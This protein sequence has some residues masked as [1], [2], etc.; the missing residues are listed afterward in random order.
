MQTPYGI[1]LF[2]F[3]PR[4]RRE[5]NDSWLIPE[6]VAKVGTVD[7]DFAVGLVAGCWLLVPR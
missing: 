5:I 1:V 6:I 3:I 4:R 2:R 7:D